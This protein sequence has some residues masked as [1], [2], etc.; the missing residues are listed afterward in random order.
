MRRALVLTIGMAPV[1][2]E[3]LLFAT[4]AASTGPVRSVG[5]LAP[6]C[7]SRMNLR[8][9]RVGA[10]LNAQRLKGGGGADLVARKRAMELLYFVMYCALA[11]QGRFLSLFFRDTLGL[12]NQQIGYVFGA[13]TVVGLFSTPIWSALCDYLQR[14]RLVI[15]VIFGG[16][17]ASALLYLL[18]L[19]TT[20]LNVFWWT[21]MARCLYAFYMSPAMGILD[22]VAV[23]TLAAKGDFGQCRL[24]G[25]IAWAVLGA[26]LGALLHAGVPGW[27]QPVGFVGCAVLFIT[28][29]Q[30]QPFES[31]NDAQGVTPALKA[32]GVLGAEKKGFGGKGIVEGGGEVA[33]RGLRDVLRDTCLIVWGERWVSVTFFLVLFVLGGATSVQILTSQSSIGIVRL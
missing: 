25:S 16:G 13:G 2:V 7:P 15:S 18:P 17:A 32:N 3:G 23:N 6:S 24:W 14:K 9:W 1:L 8:A 20:A 5:Q 4:T 11:C 10:S 31:N 26:L 33:A 12:S 28:A 30:L 21:L 27:I 19:T 22:S 29:I